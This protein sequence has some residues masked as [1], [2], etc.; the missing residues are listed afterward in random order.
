[1]PRPI[2]RE[3]VSLAINALAIAMESGELTPAEFKRAG[4]ARA[5]LYDLSEWKAPAEPAPRR[6]TP[7]TGMRRRF[8]R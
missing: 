6:L 7:V 5:V 1:M 8:G 2:A 4:E 3:D